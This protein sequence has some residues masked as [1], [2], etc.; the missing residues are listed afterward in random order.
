MFKDGNS[1]FTKVMFLTA[2]IVGHVSWTWGQENHTVGK[3]LVERLHG[4]WL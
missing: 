3:S 2:E 1:T 4:L